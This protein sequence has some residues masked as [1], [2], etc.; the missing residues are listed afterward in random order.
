MRPAHRHDGLTFG[1]L[2]IGACR[3]VRIDQHQ[4]ADAAA[5]R[6][7]KQGFELRRVDEPGT[8]VLQLVFDRVHAFQTRDRF[9]QRIA[10]FRREHRVAGVAQQLEQPRIRLRCGAEQIQMVG[11]DGADAKTGDIIPVRG[12][13]CIRNVRADT[14]VV[15][16][17]D[18]RLT[19]TVRRPPGQERGQRLARRTVAARVGG[20][21]SRHLHRG[22]AVACGIRIVQLTEGDAVA[23]RHGL[24]LGDGIGFA[25]VDTG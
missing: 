13:G 14:G 4:R 25:D 6:A 11:I 5:V 20:V 1:R 16:M 10:G 15:R 21:R 19:W 17:A 12:V 2:D 3:I 9:D 7:V 8:V 23:A 22:Q 18:V 24:G